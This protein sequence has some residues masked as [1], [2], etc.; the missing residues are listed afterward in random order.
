MGTLIDPRDVASQG[1]RQLHSIT[2]VEAENGQM[3]LKLTPLDVGL[4]NLSS[5]PF[6][7]H[8]TDL[9]D[10]TKGGRFVLFNNKW[11]T[12]FSMWTGGDQTF[13]FKLE[14]ALKT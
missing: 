3:S 6:L 1:N 8:T 9:P 2:A 4:V 5:L 12:N 13:R 7:R 14:F 11:G 10:P